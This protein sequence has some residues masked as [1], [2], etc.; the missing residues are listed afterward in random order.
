[1]DPTCWAA[2]ALIHTGQA[3]NG[4]AGPMNCVTPSALAALWFPSHQRAFATSV[5]YGIQMAGPSVGFLL[6]FSVRN[7]Q[8]LIFLMEM[9]ALFSLLV[10]AAWGCLPRKPKHPPSLSQEL[11]S[12]GSSGAAEPV[13]LRRW[14]SASVLV[15]AGSLAV[16]V[17]QCWSPAL[18]TQLEGVLPNGLLKWFS[19]ITSVASLVGNFAAPFL[20]EALHLQLKLKLALVAA[21]LVQANIVRSRAMVVFDSQTLAQD[22]QFSG[23]QLANSAWGFSWLNVSGDT[24]RE[25][26]AAAAKTVALDPQSVGALIDA[27]IKSEA[28]ENQMLE[29][30]GHLLEVLP[31][32]SEQWDSASPGLFMDSIP[33][34]TLGVLGTSGLLRAWSVKEEKDIQH[35]AE[36]A[37][38]RHFQRPEDMYDWPWAFL[39]W[40]ETILTLLAR[41]VVVS[42]LLLA[43][44]VCCFVTGPISAETKTWP[45]DWGDY[46]TIF[47]GGLRPLVRWCGTTLAFIIWDNLT[48][49]TGLSSAEPGESEAWWAEARFR[50]LGRLAAKLASADTGPL[51]AVNFKRKDGSWESLGSGPSPFRT[52]SGELTASFS[53][54]SPLHS[55]APSRRLL[56]YGQLRVPNFIDLLSGSRETVGLLLATDS[57]ILER[58]DDC[59]EGAC[60]VSALQVRGKRLEQEAAEEQ[61]PYLCQFQPWL[62][63]CYYQAKQ[64][65]SPPP[66]PPG[67]PPAFCQYYPLSPYCLPSGA[68]YPAPAP[69]YQP[70]PTQYSPLPS[71]TPAPAAP[72]PIPMAPAAPVRMMRRGGLDPPAKATTYNGASWETMRIGGTKT[73]HFFAVGDWGSLLGSGYAPMIQYR[74]GHTPGPH[75]MARW[76]GPCKTKMMVECFAGGV[77]E[78]SCHFSEVDRQ[79]QALVAKQMKQRAAES[80][81]D[82]VVNVGDNFYWGGVN[83][84]CG[85][86]MNQISA[87]TQQQFTEIFERIYNGPGLDGIPWLSVLGNHDWGGFQFNKAWDQQI[88]YT[89]TSDRW[90]MPGLYWMQRVEYPDQDFSA[91]FLMIDSNAMD[92]KPMHADPE[93]NICGQKHNPADARCDATGGPANLK[94]CFSW[95]W[96]IWKDQQKWV[97][98]KLSGSTADWQIIA[99]HFNC[100]HQAEWYKKLHQQYGLDLLITGHTHD[101]QVFH[102]SGLLGGMTCFITGGGGGIVSEGDPSNYRS[103]QYGF[104]D[105]TISK[106]EIVL[107]SVNYNGVSLG[108]YSVEP[109]ARP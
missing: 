27:G 72:A 83:T 28:L 103:N 22:A 88:A 2:H 11:R 24:F 64:M 33:A 60:A 46:L 74:G 67:L 99:T 87:I 26:A 7:S 86:P 105:L 20:I 97:E 108:K 56:G 53:S 70:P 12:R 94:D 104:F 48:R 36:E 32:T 96:G 15:M 31:G 16:G 25:S 58:D 107:E 8:Q 69:M 76:R 37:A 50:L 101:Q 57:E 63:Q 65:P 55:R 4:M 5:V 40:E 91:E 109:K 79:A 39:E 51:P 62:P 42:A 82:F 44:W 81:P 29:I 30:L 84:K 66:P 89:W 45:N 1:M 3:L 100:G 90:R 71:L 41:K 23:I 77:C 43:R 102:K 98:E 92:V 38:A 68:Q 6:A 106:K 47:C 34:D 59:A 18:P 80:G 13:P 93:H 21:L 19:V 17:F 75:T 35:P 73:M 9:E 78:K 10:L 61:V 85:T 49:E 54:C 14:I 52:G 95:M